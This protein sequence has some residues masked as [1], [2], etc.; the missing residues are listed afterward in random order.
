MSGHVVIEPSVLY[1][2]TPAYLIGTQHPDGSPSLAA[3]SSYWAIGKIVVLGIEDDGQ[4]LPNILERGE[5]TVNFP[6]AALWREVSR[7]AYLTGRD[8]IPVDKQGKYRHEADKFAAAG[9]TPQASDLV[10][11]P[12]VQECAL[13][14]E[15]RL[16]RATHGVDGGYHM[17]E[18]EV[19]RVHADP[20]IVV[21]GTNHV[22]PAAWD[23]LIYS[24]RHFFHRGGEVGWL[25]SS[26]TASGPAPLD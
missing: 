4:S 10:A 8:P 9:L 25:P 7:L 13:Q 18:A 2:G 6:T 14:F 1:V 15:A 22:D 19:V 16:R 17:V 12:R 5:L 20:A 21:P 26:P 24:F 11:A 3:A 23:P